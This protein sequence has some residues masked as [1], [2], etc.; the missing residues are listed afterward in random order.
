MSSAH[1]RPGVE[2][3]SAT[4]CSSRH[5]SSERAAEWGDEL[6]TLARRYDARY[7][8]TAFCHNDLVAANVLDDGQ[9]ALVDFEYAVR[10]DPLLD[11]ANAAGMAA[12]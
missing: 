12:S 8:P 7:A 10:A 5:S 3:S 11:L 1:S 4:S 9:L 6:L 2:S